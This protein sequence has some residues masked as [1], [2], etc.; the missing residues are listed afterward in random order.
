MKPDLISRDYKAR[1]GYVSVVCCKC[2]NALHIKEGKRE[3]T[4]TFD[5]PC[6][7]RM[8]LHRGKYF[9]KYYL[10]NGLSSPIKD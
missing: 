2:G 9:T 3:D 6:G 8:Y 10:N 4:T 7:N 1:L 5:C